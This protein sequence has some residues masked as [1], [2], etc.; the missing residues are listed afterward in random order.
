MGSIIAALRRSEEEVDLRG[1][2]LRVCVLAKRRLLQMQ[3]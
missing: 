1:R 3:W 2:D